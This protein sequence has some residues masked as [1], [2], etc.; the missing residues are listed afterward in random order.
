MA[1]GAGEGPPLVAR[2]FRGTYHQKVD[3]KG[4][5]SIPAAFRRV[6]EAGDPDWTDGQR[7]NLVMVYGLKTQA[8]LDFFTVNAIEEIEERI[9]RMPRGPDRDFLEMT[10]H[11]SVEDMQIDEDGRI[12]LPQRHRDKIGLEANETAM[13]IARSDHFQIWKQATFDAV[14]ARRSDVFHVD[15]PGDYDPRELLPDLEG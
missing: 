11:S 8:R 7:P 9:A 12:V 15:R 2:R 13:F 6:V 4:R 14:V 10:Y 5:V 1:R 3:S